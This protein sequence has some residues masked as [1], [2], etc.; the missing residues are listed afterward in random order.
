MP[1]HV[2]STMCSLSGGQNCIIQ[3]LVSSHLKVA[4]PCTR[5]RDGQLQVYF[6]VRDYY[7]ADFVI[8]LLAVAKYKEPQGYIHENMCQI[9]RS[10]YYTRYLT[11]FANWHNLLTPELVF[12]FLI[13]AHPVYKMWIIQEPNTLALWNKLHF[14]E[15]KTESIKHV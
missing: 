9:F 7:R 14:E 12:F 10:G 5:A 13:L 1:L 6:G 2:S 15:K 11:P 8:V 3:Y 4:V